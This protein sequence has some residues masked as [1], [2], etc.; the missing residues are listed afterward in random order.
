[1]S[2]SQLSPRGAIFTGLLFTAGGGVAILNSLDVIGLSALT[3]GTPVWV[4]VCAGLVFI[5]GG[6]AVVLDYAVAGLGPDGDFLPGTPFAIRLANLLL[7]MAIV[8]GMIA[9]SGWIAF[10]TGPRRFS[11]SVSIPFVAT[12]WTTGATFG[13]IVFGAGTV[14]MVFMFVACTVVGI[15]RLWRARRE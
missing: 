15:R 7:G 9:I 10:G 2:S 3:P 12:H 1:M 14:L 13:R 6:V 5:V 11:G 4:G 8:G